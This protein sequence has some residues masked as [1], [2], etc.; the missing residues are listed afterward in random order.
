MLIVLDVTIR[1]IDNHIDTNDHT[2]THTHTYT[3]TNPIT[4]HSHPGSSC[5]WVH[6]VRVHLRLPTL[7]GLYL[8][9]YR[10]VPALN[11]VTLYVET[12]VIGVS[13]GLEAL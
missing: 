7:E 6:T 5:R 1:H 11:G 4:N 2:H 12:P 3:Y 13:V 9:L 10:H 8:Q